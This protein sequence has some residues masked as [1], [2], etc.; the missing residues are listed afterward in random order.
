V[1]R[2]ASITA[3]PWPRSAL[4]VAGGACPGIRCEVTNCEARGGAAS[5]ACSANQSAPSLASA[6]P[7]ARG[8][9]HAGHPGSARGRAAPP[10]RARVRRAAVPS[11]RRTCVLMAWSSARRPP[12]VAP[13]P[14]ASSA[15]RCQ[16]SRAASRKGAR[17]ACAASSRAHSAPAAPAPAPPVSCAALGQGGCDALRCGLGK[18]APRT[19]QELRC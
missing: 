4:R 19:L 6:G 14:A 16:R 11:S 13:P 17:P 15:L 10:A 5:A 7:P 12:R 3:W 2:Q 1:H 9:A 8:H 18:R